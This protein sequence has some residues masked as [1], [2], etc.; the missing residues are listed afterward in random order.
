VRILLRRALSDE[1]QPRNSAGSSE[2]PLCSPSITSL[3][4]TFRLPIPGRSKQAHRF[5]APLVCSVCS[6]FAGIQLFGTGPSSVSSP[7][8]DQVRTG[9]PTHKLQRPSD[10][11]SNPCGMGSSKS[12]PTMARFHGTGLVHYPPANSYNL[13]MDYG[14]STDDTPSATHQRLRT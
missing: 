11:L 14:P 8:I 7:V 10:L 1:L 6:T 13:A 2:D 9:R 12:E 4:G 5:S 3:P